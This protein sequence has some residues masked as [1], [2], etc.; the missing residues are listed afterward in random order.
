MN[1][2]R[3]TPRHIIIKMPKVKDKERIPKI[4]RE[5]Q[6]VSHKG[7]PIRLS[8]DLSTEIFQ[9]RRDGK[10]TRAYN[11]D[12]STKQN[13]HLELKAKEPLRQEK[14]KGI[15]HHKNSITRN[16]NQSSLRR[17]RK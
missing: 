10:K 11:Q 9:A 5:K 17:I 6:Q 16:D 15:N 7:T 3:L 12:Y 4:A 14:A 1:P 13:Y 2:K 8:A